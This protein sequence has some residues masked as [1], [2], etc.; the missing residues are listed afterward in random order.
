MSF[1]IALSGI[2][3]IN[4]ELD[5]TSH[6]IANAGTYGYKSTRANFSTLIAGNQPTGTEIGSTTQS[7]GL[8]GGTLNTGRA[9][10]ASIA[11]RG[12]F[13][14]KDAASGQSEYTRVGIFDTSKDGFLIDA[15]GRKVQGFGIK[16]PSN[17]L[18]ALGDITIPNGQIP[19]VASTKLNY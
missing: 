18:G 6:N 7:I 19:A 11:G 5:Q 12:F 9:L 16:P 8:A 13:V 3:A 1:D 14:V 17:I 4:E 10:D 15:S 2:Q